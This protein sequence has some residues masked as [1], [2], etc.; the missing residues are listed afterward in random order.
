MHEALAGGLHILGVELVGIVQRDGVGAGLRRVDQRFENRKQASRG[1]AE[2]SPPAR[3]AS[4]RTSGLVRPPAPA[5]RA[6]RRGR[7]GVFPNLLDVE[8]HDQ[9]VA[10]PQ[11]L[12]D[13]SASAQ[14]P[15]R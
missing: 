10:A 6:A 12:G 1:N 11:C 2:A 15:D 13:A 14:R 5:F 7:L 4:S 8:R 3:F 9:A